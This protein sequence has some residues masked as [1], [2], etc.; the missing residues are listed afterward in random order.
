MNPLKPVLV[1]G[2][3]ALLHT[4]AIH[5]QDIDKLKIDIE[6]KNV[7][8]AAALNKIEQL[9]SFRMTYKTEDVAPVKD[10]SYRQHQVTVKKALT[11]LLAHTGLRFEQV[12]QHI[13]IK[14]IAQSPARNATL[15]G[16]VTSQASGETLTGATITVSGEKTFYTVTNSYGFY[17]LTVPE[18]MYSLNCSYT[19][20]RDFDK[21]VDA[22]ER[23]QINIELTGKVANDLQPVVVAAT[24]NKSTVR[25]TITGHHRL[26][27]AEI[28]KIAM[29][30]GEPD[31]LKSLQFLP[32]IQTSNEGTT[33]LS[34][35]GGSYDQNL[36]LLDEAP[37]YNPSHTLGFFSTFNTDAIKDVAIYKGV[38]PSQ[39][40]GRLSSVIDVK[41]KEGNSKEHTLSGGIGLLA[42]RLTYEGPIRKERSSFMLSGRYS[43]VGLLL[44]MADKVRFL[45]FRTSNS[46][47]AFYDLNAKFNPILGNKDRLFYQPI[48]GMIIFFL[49]LLMPRTK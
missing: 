38:F 43:N 11:D 13:F 44:N 21:Q 8:L 5:A 2:L 3:Y 46:K 10:I 14:R 49:I 19:G 40:G 33:N 35:R 42:S 17:S 48:Q 30:G 1:L 45:K 16:F 9:T 31:A 24:G 20:F 34:V 27:A 47:V 41:M 37:V 4:S 26:D 25:R 6:L 39:Y 7:T 29:A 23:S 12:Q 18:G 28:K 32:G 36:V 22:R 15:Y